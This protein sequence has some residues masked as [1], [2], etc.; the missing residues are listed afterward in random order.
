MVEVQFFYL[1]G[2]WIFGSLMMLGPGKMFRCKFM[3]VNE[4][5]FM[6]KVKDVF[7]DLMVST[8][9]V[10]M[11][12]WPISF[13]FFFAWYFVNCSKFD[14]SF[15]I[16]LIVLNLSQIDYTFIIFILKLN[17]CLTY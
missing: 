10:R 8:A 3:M 14:R 4:I 13:F 11:L 2:C 12:L 6:G 9:V 7:L 15:E 1:F 16:A 17:N 5:F